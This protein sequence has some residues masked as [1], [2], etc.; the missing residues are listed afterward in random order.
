MSTLAAL[1]TATYDFPLYLKVFLAFLGGLVPVLIWLWFWEHEDKHPEPKKLIFF[2]FAAGMLSVL[3]TLPLEQVVAKTT[4]NLTILI[5]TWAA[6]EEGI[7]FIFAY[8]VVLIRKENDEPIDSVMYMITVALGFAAI[9]NAFFLFNPIFGE[10]HIEAI[11]TGNLRF[12]GATLLHTIT[13]SIIG[14]AFA[15]SFYRS[16]RARALY[17]FIGV[18]TAIVLH[19]AFNLSIISF[20]ESV[21][22]L[23]F[24][25]VWFVIVLILLAFEKVK[26]LKQPR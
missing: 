14:F 26:S 4:S 6:L 22:I 2:A 5:F 13:S 8:L 23:P 18:I 20:N 11:A 12:I 1:L 15:F 25:A 9:E 21:P 16:N 19:A 7:K 17:V 3:V 24:Y 10:Q